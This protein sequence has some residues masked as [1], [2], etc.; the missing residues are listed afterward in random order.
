MGNLLLMEGDGCRTAER[1]LSV[2]KRLQTY[3]RNA[4]SQRKINSLLMHVYQEQ[5]DNLDINAI[6]TSFVVTRNVKIY[7]ALYKSAK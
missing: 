5:V 4:L 6:V 3:L 2:L 1:S 7:L